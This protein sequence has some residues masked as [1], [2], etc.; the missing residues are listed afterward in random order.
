MLSRTKCGPDASRPPV[1]LTG[2]PRR[3]AGKQPPDTPAREISRGAGLRYVSDA[4]PGFTRKPAGT[5]FIYRDVDGRRIRDRE[6]L[7]RMASLAIPPAYTDVWISPCENG[8]IQAT[9]R[10]ARG[11]KQFRYHP[12]WREI[13]DGDKYNRMLAFGTALPHIRLRVARDLA[14]PGMPRNKILATLVRLLETTHIR[15][16]NEEYRRTNHSFGLTTLR[17][18]HVE[19]MGGTLRFEFKGKGG[20]PHSIAVADP[21]VARI[22][23]QCLD[24][25]GQQ[26]FQ[27]LDEEG[28]RHSVSSGDLNEYLHGIAGEEFTAKDFRTWAGTLLAARE[29]R[30]ADP[31]GSA[32]QS[33]H[34][35]V[36]AIRRTARH[37]GTAAVQR[38][39]PCCV[40]FR[41][42]PAR[43][44]R[45][46]CIDLA[47][48]VT[49][50][51]RSP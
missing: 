23:R 35:V 1:S 12:R 14:L 41:T 42:A 5:G 29:L 2:N 26:L 19:I 7:L 8:H 25:P 22:V 31:A 40:S 9:G 27:Y 4:E 24:I 10:D 51:E 3:R 37:L 18:R 17:N 11:R 28:R 21:R 46:D 6:T 32:T 43:R 34:N 38:K 13:R 33:K 39:R 15:V 47:P 48:R 30:A 49:T 36:E 44:V 16:G 50:D 20:K 45:R